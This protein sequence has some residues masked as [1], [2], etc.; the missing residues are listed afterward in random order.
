ATGHLKVPRCSDRKRTASQ[1]AGQCGSL[2]YQLRAAQDR[3]ARRA[4]QGKGKHLGFNRL[5]VAQER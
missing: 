3:M 1:L 4:S 2:F 5:R